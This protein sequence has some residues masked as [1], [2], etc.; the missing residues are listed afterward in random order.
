MKVLI[1]LALL[2]ANSQAV[3]VQYITRDQEARAIENAI[4]NRVVP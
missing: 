3:Q 1:S 4:V 2:F